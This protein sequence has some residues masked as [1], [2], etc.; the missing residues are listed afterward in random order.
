MNSISQ[1]Y[2]DQ[3][4]HNLN[5]AIQESYVMQK[6]IKVNKQY[7]N[8]MNQSLKKKMHSAR[9]DFSNSSKQQ[10]I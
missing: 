1:G 10:A 9:I 7:S 8:D 5:Q 6:K 2:K 4:N 3:Q